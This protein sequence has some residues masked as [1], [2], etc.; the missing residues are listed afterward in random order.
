MVNVAD[1]IREEVDLCGCFSAV[2]MYLRMFMWGLWDKYNNSNL[3]LLPPAEG[4]VVNAA[5]QLK[6]H[7]HNKAIKKKNT[8]HFK[9]INVETLNTSSVRTVGK[10][11]FN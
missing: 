7:L 10:T 2:T 4:D 6:L 11:K 9:S 8:A 3:Q 1:P 5:Q